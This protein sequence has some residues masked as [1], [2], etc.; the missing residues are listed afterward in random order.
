[1]ID[2]FGLNLLILNTKTGIIIIIIIIIIVYY[3]NT[4]GEFLFVLLIC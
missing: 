1:M 3:V 2:G 4:A